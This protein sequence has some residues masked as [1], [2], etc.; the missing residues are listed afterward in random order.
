[1][2]RF[3][4]QLR[5]LRLP[6]RKALQVASELGARGVEIDLRHEIAPRELSQTGVRQFRKL[7]EDLNLKVCAATYPT[8]RGYYDSEDLDRRILATKEAIDCAYKL[9]APVLT[10]HLGRVPAEETDPNFTLLRDVMSEIGRYAH[11]QGV[12]MTAK[13]GPESAADLNRLLDVLP[14]GLLGVEFDP[15]ALIVNG[16]SA[17]ESLE[18]LIKHV[19]HVRAKDGVRDLAIGRGIEVELG[20]GSADFPMLLAILDDAGYNGFLTVVRENPQSPRAEI[21]QSLEYLRQLVPHAE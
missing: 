20:R 15:G 21:E 18:A 19:R 1:M 9:G 2:F 4:V 16:F 11:Q 8:R 10:N 17:R 3:G 6:V 7:L 14:D 12:F 13:T 5:S